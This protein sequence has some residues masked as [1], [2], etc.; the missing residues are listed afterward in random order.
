[1]NSVRELKLNGEA[2]Y[3][4]GEEARAAAASILKLSAATADLPG[5][6]INKIA[7]AVGALTTNK[8]Q[9]VY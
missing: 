8:V 1:M 2:A 5:E 7:D 6:I 4:I 3:L 9:A